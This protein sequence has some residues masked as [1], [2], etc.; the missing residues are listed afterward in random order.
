MTK[1]FAIYTIALAA[2]SAAITGAIVA[3]NRKKLANST[4]GNE[5]VQEVMSNAEFAVEA[6]QQATETAQKLHQ[7]A[8]D[9]HQQ[10][11]MG[12]M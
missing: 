4:L 10:M 5:S 6:S 3:H 8:V 2:T 12:M 1:K 9:V 7:E 11:M